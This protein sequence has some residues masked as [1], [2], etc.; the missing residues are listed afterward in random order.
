MHEAKITGR[1][2]TGS[3]MDLKRYSEFIAESY[4]LMHHI[5]AERLLRSPYA[6]HRK[7]LFRRIIMLI[8]GR[9]C[10][11]LIRIKDL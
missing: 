6:T 10:F 11:T 8:K 4:A 2:I 9:S 5:I 1:R 3:R 7:I